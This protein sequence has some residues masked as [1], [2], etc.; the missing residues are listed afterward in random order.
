MGD[1]S[2]MFHLSWMVLVM[3]WLAGL[4]ITNQTKAHLVRNVG[5]VKEIDRWDGMV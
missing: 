3:S 1:L 4:D 2:T 5:L